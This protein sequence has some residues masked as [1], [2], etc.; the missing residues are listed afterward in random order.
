MSADVNQKENLGENEPLVSVGIPTF[1]R[2]EGLRR[3]LGYIC[4]QTYKNLEIIIS[5]NASP[6]DETLRVVEEFMARDKRIQYFRQSSNLGP[7]ANFQFV[8]DAATGEYFMWM[9]DDDWRDSR[10]IEVL[11]DEMKADNS[12]VIA[13]CDFSVFDEHGNRRRDFHQTHFPYLKRLVSS[14]APIRLIKFF[15]QDESLGKANIIYGLLRRSAIKD[16][17][18][19]SMVDRYEFYGLDNLVVFELLRKGTLRLAKEMLYGCTVGNVK[20][21]QSSKRPFQQGK[22]QVISKQLDYLLAY[23]WLCDGFF[24]VVIALIFPLKLISFYWCVLKSKISLRW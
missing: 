4:N 13:F 19:A 20:Y 10:F 2:P 7:V 3:S 23:V 16:I 11:L 12:A 21:Y 8:L 24:R 22:L 18:L 5:D 6:G 14:S 9:S 15:L 1:S 17:S